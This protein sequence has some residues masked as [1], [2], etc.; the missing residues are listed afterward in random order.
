MI[1]CNFCISIPTIAN[2]MR[3][4]RSHPTTES[5]SAVGSVRYRPTYL[6]DIPYAILHHN[7]EEWDPATNPKPNLPI[8]YLPRTWYFCTRGMH[9]LSFLGRAFS[10]HDLILYKFLKLSCMQQWIHRALTFE[11]PHR[12]CALVL[13]F[14]V[15]AHWILAMAIK[16]ILAECPQGQKCRGPVTAVMA[17]HRGIKIKSTLELN[18]LG[19][20]HTGP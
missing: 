19:P 13:P 3:H 8:H 5:V 16:P 11:I 4:S 12:A 6:T 15:W 2:W 9:N 20:I 10:P 18:H 7:F 17:Y 1:S 14:P